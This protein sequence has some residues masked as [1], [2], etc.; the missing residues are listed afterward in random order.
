MESADLKEPSWGRPKDASTLCPPSLRNFSP[1]CSPVVP[2]SLVLAVN[3]VRREVNS[4]RNYGRELGM[5]S[6]AWNDLDLRTSWIVW[7]H[8]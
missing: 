8:V 3:G 4:Y 5:Q 6:V 2:A 1:V 7:L